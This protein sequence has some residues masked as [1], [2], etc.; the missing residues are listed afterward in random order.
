MNILEAQAKDVVGN[1]ISNY[2]VAAAMQW[3]YY[4]RNLTEEESLLLKELILSYLILGA[5]E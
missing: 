3:H 2:P 4:D 1:F 5:P